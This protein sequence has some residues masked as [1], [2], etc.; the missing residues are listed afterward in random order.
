M[1]FI[2]RWNGSSWVEAPVM[3]WNGSVW[4][5]VRVYKDGSSTKLQGIIRTTTIAPSSIYTVNHGTTTVD[6][7]FESSAV[8][9]KWTG[10]SYSKDG[11]FVFPTSTLLS[12]LS[13]AVEVHYFQMRIRRKNSTHG[14]SAAVAP[15]A[16]NFSASFNAVL[17]GEWTNWANISTSLIDGSSMLLKIYTSVQTG[18][19]IADSAE[20]R[21]S[22]EN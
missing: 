17:R 19:L 1:G 7:Y 16:S 2:K 20:I 15:V 12:M 13:G 11:V 6:S 21:L 5:R 8:Q 9:G 22:V 14:Y 3:K 18:Y 4:E 10:M